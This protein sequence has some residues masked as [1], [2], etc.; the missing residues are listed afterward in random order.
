MVLSCCGRRSTALKVFPW[1]H[2][3]RQLLG[4]GK[5]LHGSDRGVEITRQFQEDK[6]SLAAYNLKDCELVSDI[7]AAT[8]LLDFAVARSAMTGLNLDR[9]GGSV[10]SFDNLY[11]P[12]L[13]RAGYVA[14]NA[15]SEHIASPGGF[16]L[17]SMPGIYDHVLLLDFKSLYPSIIR[18]FCIDPLGLALGVSGQLSAATDSGRVFWMGASPATDISCRH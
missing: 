4:D 2:V 18:T 8:A 3:A 7:F 6:T 14:P 12:R 11:L 16:V 1:K 10:A 9:M 15:S 13:H 17:D 5:L